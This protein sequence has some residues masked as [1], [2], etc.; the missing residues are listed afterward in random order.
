VNTTWKTP[1]GRAFARMHKQITGCELAALDLA[2]LAA[3]F[4]L[5]EREAE[6]ASAF[7]RFGRQTESFDDHH[8]LLAMIAFADICMQEAR[9]G[10]IDNGAA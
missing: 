7:M 9:N 2:A 10:S 3:V 8:R 6:I 1:V 5:T 4:Q